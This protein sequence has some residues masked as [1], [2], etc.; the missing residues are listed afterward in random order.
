MEETVPSAAEAEW[1]EIV[2][3]IYPHPTGWTSNVSLRLHKGAALKWTRH[4]DI[5][6][7]QVED[8]SG[9]STTAAVLVAV[10]AHL[11]EIADRA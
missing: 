7:N 9:V 6:K 8:M 4:L 2:V 1:R 5:H 10:A 3:R 11:M